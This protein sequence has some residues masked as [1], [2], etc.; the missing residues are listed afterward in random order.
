MGPCSGVKHNATLYVLYM[1]IV[2]SYLQWYIHNTCYVE[3]SYVTQSFFGAISV[4]FL[5]SNASPFKW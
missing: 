5:F 1:Y 3:A 2:N 4:F